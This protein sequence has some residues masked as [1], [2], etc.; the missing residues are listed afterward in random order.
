MGIFILN[1]GGVEFKTSKS[2]LENKDHFFAAFVRNQQY[3]QSDCISL[4]F[5][6]RDPTH[7]RYILNYM[8][9]SNIL[10]TDPT[11]LKELRVEADY[12]SMN[13][14]VNMLNDKITRDVIQS[15]GI[16]QELKRI[17]EKLP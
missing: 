10:P 1:I 9:G 17:R 8:R 7:F 11:T 16:E 3:E 5:V 2:T 4:P 14:L 13:D 6:D 15:I 12:Y